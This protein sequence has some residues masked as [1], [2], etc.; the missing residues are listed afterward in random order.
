MAWRLGGLASLPG[1]QD[2]GPGAISARRSTS[3]R[4]AISGGWTQNWPVDSSPR[5]LEYALS[6]LST[7]MVTYPAFAQPV[8]LFDAHM[9]RINNALIY[10]RTA[11]VD[12]ADDKPILSISL[13]GRGLRRANRNALEILAVLEAD[14]TPL[15]AIERRA[16]NE[17]KP[18]GDARER[19]Q[20]PS[21]MM[22]A[23]GIVRPLVSKKRSSAVGDGAGLH[24]LRMLLDHV[25]SVFQDAA[26]PFVLTSDGHVFAKRLFEKPDEAA[27]LAKKTAK[28]LKKEKKDAAE[29]KALPFVDI[30]GLPSPQSVRN[31]L[32]AAGYAGVRF[33]CGP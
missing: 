16:D 32:S 19:A 28:R 11:M 25:Q 26:E 21:F 12:Q 29:Y 10:S 31:S 7:R 3:L 1:T 5:E 2:R 23:P 33:V 24:H 15:G 30:F 27:E 22:P 9:R 4:P 6:Y 14:R 8:I 13:D 18:L 17:K 20:K